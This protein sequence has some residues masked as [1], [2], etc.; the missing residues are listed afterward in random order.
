MKTLK[1][2]LLMA[3]VMTMS[4]TM[5]ADDDDRVIT[6]SQLP[7]AAQTFL[8]AHFGTKVP[9]LVTADW[10][11]YTIRYESGEKIEFNRSGDW[12]DIE[13]YNS[14]VPNEAVPAQISTYISQ[15]YPGKSIIK[16]ERHRSVYEVKLNNGLEVEFNRNFQLICVD[17]DD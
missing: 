7:E 16:L 10:D 15:N 4:L 2:F 5:S 13:C 17:Y 12:K 9:L 6:F 14:K 8:K 3:M 1:Y 11:D